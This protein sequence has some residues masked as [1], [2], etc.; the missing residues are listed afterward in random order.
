[1]YIVEDTIIKPANTKWFSDQHP[2]L[3]EQISDR[4]ALFSGLIGIDIKR[5]D[6]N[7]IVKTYVFS[8]ENEYNKFVE[9]EK[10]DSN[11]QVRDNYNLAHGII[12]TRTVIN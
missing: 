11:D 7:T 4:N 1:M 9:T 5:P 10:Q 2:E 6:Q 3:T 8:D 12:S